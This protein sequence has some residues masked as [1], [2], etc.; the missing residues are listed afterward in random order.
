[1]SLHWLSDIANQIVADS[2]ELKKQAKTIKDS[3]NKNKN[4]NSSDKNSNNKKK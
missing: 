1:M 2:A 3:I 4:N